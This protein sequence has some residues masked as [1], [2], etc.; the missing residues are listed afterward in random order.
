MG[1]TLRSTAMAAA[2]MF[3]VYERKPGHPKETHT[4][5]EPPSQKC[6]C[7]RHKIHI[8][9]LVCCPDIS[10][11]PSRQS[12][13]ITWQFLRKCQVISEGIRKPRGST[14]L[15]LSVKMCLSNFYTAKDN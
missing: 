13:A 2:V 15:V 10:V 3:L 14:R 4:G 6:S 5:Y 9:P 8:R 12:S 11:F 7:S 1:S